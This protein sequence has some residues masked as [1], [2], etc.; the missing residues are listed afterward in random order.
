MTKLTKIEKIFYVLLERIIVVKV[1]NAPLKSAPPRP[2]GTHFIRI[3]GL[4]V[5]TVITGF[6][7]AGVPIFTVR[8]KRM[9]VILIIDYINNT[10][11][12][13]A[14]PLHSGGDFRN[15]KSH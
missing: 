15:S 3:Q 2:A 12:A 11:S 4:A 7:R 13:G 14:A 8:D 1:I 6:R 10:A 5:E 9:R